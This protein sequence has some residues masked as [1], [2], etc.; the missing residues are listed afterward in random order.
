MAGQVRG[1]L[2]EG[3]IDLDTNS[4]ENAIRP[5]IIFRKNSLFAGNEQG[6]SGSHYF[7][8]CWKLASSIIS[9]FINS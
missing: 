3:E 7:I 4:A 1:L 8:F 6:G 9:I 5:V 2:L